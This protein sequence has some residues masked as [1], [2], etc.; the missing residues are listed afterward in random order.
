MEIYQKNILK[1]DPRSKD[2]KCFFEASSYCSRYKDCTDSSHSEK[3]DKHRLIQCADD[4]DQIY[5]EIRIRIKLNFKIRILIIL[6]L[7]T[8]SN[9]K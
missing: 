1:S 4:P 6:F 5:F 7:N 2:M 9:T 8:D 3:I